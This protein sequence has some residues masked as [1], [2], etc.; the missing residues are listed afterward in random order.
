MQNS[1]S[2]RDDRGLSDFDAR[3][4]I[5]FSA[6]WELPFRRHLLSD[7]NLALVWQAQTGNP[8][9]ILTTNTTV[10]GVA[11]T[12]RPD[13]LG[14]VA[15]AGTVDRWFDTSAFTAVPRFGQLGRNVVPGPGF[16]SADASLTKNVRIREILRVQFRAEFFDL[17]NHPNF[18]QP[19]NVV[20]TPG[21]ARITA[22]RFPT[23]ESG[24]S[25]QVQFGL[26]VLL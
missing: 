21:F 4:R 12:L 3:H 25:R 26:K 2:L 7:W 10:N 8:V 19:G 11:G 14:P 9:N 15:M 16:R 13:V 1:Y 22:T 20:G 6:L 24:S 5:T 18:A 17:L 23:G